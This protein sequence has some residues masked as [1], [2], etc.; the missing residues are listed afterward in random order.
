MPLTILTMIGNFYNF[1]RFLRQAHIIMISRPVQLDID[2]PADRRFVEESKVDIKLRELRD[3]KLFNIILLN[4]ILKL[5][6][7]KRICQ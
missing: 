3:I 6:L 2:G 5:S 4:R 7:S 1:V